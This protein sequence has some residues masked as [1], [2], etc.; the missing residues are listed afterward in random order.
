MIKTIVCGARGRMGQ[1]VILEIQQDPTMELIGAIE[2]L[3]HPGLGKKVTEEVVV[4]ANLE[5]VAP[6]GAVIIEFTTPV[7]TLDHLKIAKR[8]KIS[9]V[10]GT[11]GFQEVELNLIREASRSIPILL[12]P[13]MSIGINL[14]FKLVQIS[15]K[16]LG[17][18]FDKEVVE[19]HHR[20]KKDAP[21]GTAKRIAQILAQVEEQRLDQVGV[22]G[23]EGTIGERRKEEIGI[24]AVRGGSVVG[25]HTVIFAGEGERLE[26]AHRAESRKIFARGAV[27][28]TKFIAQKKIGLYDLQDVL[29]IK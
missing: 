24:H 22:F 10:I 26:I 1:Q 27:L 4:S 14:L 8:K 23:R 15:A 6:E 13:N 12:S 28:A 5:E 9:M 3:H 19:V 21:S 25:D 20:R 18:E 11:T 29:G 7:A 2:S 17:K 16:T